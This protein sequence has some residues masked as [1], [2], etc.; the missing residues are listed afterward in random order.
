MRVAHGPEHVVRTGTRIDFAA[1]WLRR[2][3]KLSGDRARRSQFGD[4]LV[5]DAPRVRTFVGVLAGVGRWTLDR[6]RVCG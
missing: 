3:K 2:R 6:R 5:A 1:G 4:P